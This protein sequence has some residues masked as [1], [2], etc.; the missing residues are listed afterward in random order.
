MALEFLDILDEL[1]PSIYQLGGY[2]RMKLD[3]L[4]RHYRFIREI[5]TFGLMIGI[6]LKIPAKPILEECMADGLLVNVTQE[7]VIRFLPPYIITEQEIDKAMRI[8]DK[9]MHKGRE[10]YVESGVADELL[11][12]S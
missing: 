9:A 11:E 10:I 2:F 5:R 4:A 7:N 8:L 1:L 6:E 12:E 3:E